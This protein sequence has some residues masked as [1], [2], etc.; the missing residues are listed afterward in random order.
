MEGAPVFLIVPVRAYML[1]PGVVSCAVKVVHAYHK[2]PVRG[3]IF[4]AD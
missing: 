2:E 4:A 3:E 1:L